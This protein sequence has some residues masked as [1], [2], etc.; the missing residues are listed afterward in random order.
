MSV[1][2]VASWTNSVTRVQMSTVRRFQLK[3][4]VSEKICNDGVQSVVIDVTVQTGGSDN[5]KTARSPLWAKNAIDSFGSFV[6]AHAGCALFTL[7]AGWSREEEF[8]QMLGTAE[9]GLKIVFAH[10]S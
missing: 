9:M 1:A 2:V 8:K 3:N 6:A 5:A 10:I 7:D 4:F